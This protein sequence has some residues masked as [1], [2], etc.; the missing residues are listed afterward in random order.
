[1]PYSPRQGR[2][3]IRSPQPSGPFYIEQETE[4]ARYYFT[5]FRGPPT[6]EKM[7][8]ELESA[9]AATLSQPAVERGRKEIFS[10]RLVLLNLVRFWQQQLRRHNTSS[11]LSEFCT[12]VFEYIGWPTEGLDA[13]LAKVLPAA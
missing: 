2:T 4:Q 7:L 12:R 11:D 3:P 1:M 5:K 8:F 10:R 6:A 9:L 13:A